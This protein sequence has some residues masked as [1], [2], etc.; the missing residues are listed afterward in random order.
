MTRCQQPCQS[1]LYLPHSE[2]SL[3]LLATVLLEVGVF[4]TIVNSLA[5]VG[6]MSVEVLLGF[7]VKKKIPIKPLE[8]KQVPK[9]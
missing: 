3:G 8:V 4:P 2:G 1:R 7:V 6:V 9:H 5:I